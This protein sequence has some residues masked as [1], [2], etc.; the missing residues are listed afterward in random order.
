M[1]PTRQR[2]AATA[3]VA[4]FFACAAITLRAQTRPDVLTQHNNNARTG[5]TLTETILTPSSVSPQTFGRLFGLGPVDGQVYAQP[6]Y[7]SQFSIGG[8]ARNVL[9]VATEHNSVYAFDADG[10]PTT[11]LWHITLGPPAPQDPVNDPSNANIPD[12]PNLTPEVGITSTPVIDRNTQTI[13]VV[14]KTLDVAGNYH[15]QLFALS[16]TTGQVRGAMEIAANLTVNGVTTTFDPRLHLNRPGLLLTGG[17]IVMAFG[18]LCDYGPY[19]GW[20]LAYDAG[21]LQQTGVYSVT[22]TGQDAEGAVWQSGQGLAADG[23]S[24]IYFLSGNGDFD[25]AAN[26]SDSAIKLNASGGQLTLV[27]F[28][29]P[30]NWPSLNVVDWDVGAGGAVLIP[31]TNLFVGGGKEG[32]LYVLDRNNLGG[33]DPSADH[34]VQSF[35]A[36]DAPGFNWIMGSPVYWTSPSGGRLY[37]WAG[38]EALKA[39]AFDGSAFDPN[40]IGQS[41][42][43]AGGTPGGILSVSANGSASGTG[44]VWASLPTADAFDETQP[45]ILRAFDAEDVSHELWNSTIDANDDVGSFAK[46]CPPTIA[47]GK[48]YLATFSGEVEVYGLRSGSSGG[49]VPSPWVNGDIGSTGLRGTATYA[50]GTFRVSGAGSDIWGTDDSFHFVR[51][52]RSGDLQIVARVDAMSNTDEWAKAGIMIRASSAPESANVLLDLTPS[53]AIE[54]LERSSD[55]ASTAGIAGSSLSFP[56]WLKLE[57]TGTTVTASIS[58]DGSNWTTVGTTSLSI[59][60]DALVGLAVTSHNPSI[61]N[62]ATF[63]N[64]SVTG[65]TG[66]GGGGGS[67]PPPWT[68]QDIGATGVAGSGSASNGVFEVDGAG[69]DIWG[70]SDSFHYVLQSVSGDVEMTARVVGIDNTDQWAK[71]GIM[72]RASTAADAANVLIDETP[73]GTIEMLERSASGTSTFGVAGASLPMPGWLKLT[74]SGSSVTGSISPDGSTWT[75]VATTTLSIGTDALIGL[76]VTSH[77]PSRLNHAMFDNVSVNGSGGSP[78]PATSDVVIY[79]EDVT[80]LR[81]SW[82]TGNDA[83]AADGWRLTTPNVGIANTPNALA[84]PTDY[85]DVTFSAAAGVPYTLWLRMQA[86]NNDKLNDSVWVQ[87][88]DAT[89]NGSAVYP[90]NTM[91][92]LLVNLA[93]D[94]TGGSLNGWGWQNSAYWLSQATTVVFSTSGTHILR[95][96][97]REDGVSIDQIV[98]SSSTYL[99]SPP[100]SPTNDSTIVPKP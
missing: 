72:L 22:P 8:A 47:N 48:V 37:L 94:G 84:S 73:D 12:C 52:A 31:G 33:F 51:Q 75:T 99:K 45:G 39:F 6:L 70:P 83:T 74:R 30:F 44:V 59:G 40:P 19:H 76:A 77:D 11:P 88:S 65:G 20:V 81:G 100:G 9:I 36:T 32:R 34:V 86:T 78:P 14:A 49:S 63:D 91:S 66:G 29:T 64:V 7:V 1:G 17:S 50:N 69:A 15:Q 96:Q 82:T 80:A 16:L 54:F 68:Q 28:F 43:T 62:T 90:L 95:V 56:G 42:A 97:V 61:I 79:A 38:N 85:F 57:R 46:F 89:S 10:A 35:Q 53:G 5:A 87:F 18:S 23:A 93:T 41:F 58:G 13:Y 21:S 92:G 4:I 27:D 26:L 60:A 71:A 98:L 2:L 25:A 67:L 3:C 24:N 55:G